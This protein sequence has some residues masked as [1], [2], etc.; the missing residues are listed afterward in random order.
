[1]LLHWV[2]HAPVVP[3]V[4]LAGQWMTCFPSCDGTEATS[5]STLTVCIYTNYIP[6][7][8]LNSDG[9]ELSILSILILKVTKIRKNPVSNKELLK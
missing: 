6:V 4:D 1:M 2:K 9:L 7:P 3:P 8:L 5:V